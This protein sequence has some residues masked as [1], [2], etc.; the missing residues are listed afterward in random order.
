MRAPLE[1]QLSPVPAPGLSR[2]GAEHR[3][4]V[5]L[6][7]TTEPTRYWSKSS[8]PTL[9]ADIGCAWAQSMADA[10]RELTLPSGLSC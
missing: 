7:E 1:P 9:P 4:S 6:I 3:L 2:E 8:L 5:L 10:E